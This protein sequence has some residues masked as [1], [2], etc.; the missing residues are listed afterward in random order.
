[1]IVQELQPAIPSTCTGRLIKIPIVPINM[2][3]VAKIKESI[4]VYAVHVSGMHYIYIYVDICTVRM[5]YSRFD[6]VQSPCIFWSKSEKVCLESTFQFVNL[7]LVEFYFVKVVL[8]HSSFNRL[9]S[10]TI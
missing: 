3:I 5:P 2:I 10:S 8:A 7:T 9:P 6:L 4:H 1:M